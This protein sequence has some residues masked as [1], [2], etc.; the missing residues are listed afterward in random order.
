M[1]FQYIVDYSYI[2]EKFGI[3][4][5]SIIIKQIEVLL[6]ERDEVAVVE[7]DEYGFDVVLYI[8]YAPNY[9]EEDD[10]Y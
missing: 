1:G 9:I 2:E 4:L 5:D 6:C 10:I 8:S 3:V 7:L